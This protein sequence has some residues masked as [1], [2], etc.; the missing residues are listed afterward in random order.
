MKARQT[1]K[2]TLLVQEIIQQL[3]SRFAPSV[4]QV[5]V[6]AHQWSITEL[7][8]NCIILFQTSIDVL[9]EKDY[10]KW[11]M[12]ENDVLDYVA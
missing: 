12:N 3:S 7:K 6:S 9:I 2:D 5:K 1:L 10:L 8:Q 4:Q 11:H